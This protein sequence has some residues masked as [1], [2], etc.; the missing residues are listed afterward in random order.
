MVNIE[1][2]DIDLP[3]DEQLSTI[4][5]ENPEEQELWI[6]LDEYIRTGSESSESPAQDV[7]LAQAIKMRDSEILSEE[8]EIPSFPPLQVTEDVWVEP[9]YTYYQHL[10]LNLHVESYAQPN[11]FDEDSRSYVELYFDSGMAKCVMDD[12]ET[13][14]YTHLRAHET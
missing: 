12:T 11:C 14:S 5:E 2:R 3:Q 9:I 1:E 13:V 6:T 10:S 7:L 4:E 8:A